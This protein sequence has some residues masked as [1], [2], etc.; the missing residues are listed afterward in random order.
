MFSRSN[1]SIV[2]DIRQGEGQIYGAELLKDL[3]KLLPDAE[4]V[5]VCVCA[6]A[7]VVCVY[8]YILNNDCTHLSAASDLLFVSFHR[9]R[10]SSPSRGTQASWPLL[11]PLCSCWSKY[12]GKDVPHGL[13]WSLLQWG[14]GGRS[15]L[16]LLRIKY[17]DCPD[18]CNE[19]MRLNITPW[20][21]LYM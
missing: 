21:P 14:E 15:S 1:H 11:I 4:E 7:Y 20:M 3:L 13:K 18:Y 6:C 19:W 16:T 9:S 12:H 2:E 8:V 10:N 17:V 5:C